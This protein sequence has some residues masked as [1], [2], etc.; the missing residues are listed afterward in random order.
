MRFI[1][2]KMETSGQ[3]MGG[4]NGN[5]GLLWD[6]WMNGQRLGRLGGEGVEKSW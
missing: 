4:L 6:W 1:D 2:N 3:S 5:Y